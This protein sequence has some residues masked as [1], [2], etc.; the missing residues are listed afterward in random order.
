MSDNKKKIQISSSFHRDAE[1]FH[2]KI[3]DHNAGTTKVIDQSEPHSTTSSKT[4]TT[5][6]VTVEASGPD[7]KAKEGDSTTVE[8]TSNLKGADTS[9]L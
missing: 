5:N 7:T 4:L 9:Q 8:A 3:E 6:P 1:T 2:E